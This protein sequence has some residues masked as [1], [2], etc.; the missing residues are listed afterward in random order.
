MFQRLRDKSTAQLFIVFMAVIDLFTCMVIIPMTAFAEFTGYKLQSDPL[1]KIYHF[2]IT[3]K[4][5]LSLFIMVAIAVDRY[6]C[7]CRPL[8]RIITRTRAKII[9]MALTLFACGLGVFSVLFHGMYHA[10]EVLDLEKIDQEAGT[11]LS[12]SPTPLIFKEDILRPLYAL[13]FSFPDC[14]IE[15]PEG[16]DYTDGEILQAANI[17]SMCEIQSL[18]QRRQM[19][20]LDVCDVSLVYLG[21]NMFY[22]YQSAYNAIFPLCLLMVFILYS[23]I[24]RFMCQRRKRKLRQK[25]ILCSY[26]NGDG[27]FENTRLVSTPP[28]PEGQAQQKGVESQMANTGGG[29]PAQL[30]PSSKLRTCEIAIPTSVSQ[31]VCLGEDSDA[32]SHCAATKKPNGDWQSPLTPDGEDKSPL[33][34]EQAL[35]NHLEAASK[36]SHPDL[37]GCSCDAIDKYGYNLMTE[38]STR[39][40]EMEIQCPGKNVFLRTDDKQPTILYHPLDKNNQSESAPHHTNNNYCKDGSPI[41]DNVSGHELSFANKFTEA[42]SSRGDLFEEEDSSRS[43]INCSRRLSH[44]HPKQKYQWH[45][46]RDSMRRYKGKSPGGKPRPQKESSSRR[47]SPLALEADRLSKENRKANVRTALMLFTVTLMFI[48]AY[49]PGWMMSMRIVP[50]N[51]LVFFLYFSYNVANPFIYAFMNHVFKTFMYKMLTCNNPQQSRI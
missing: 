11:N 43:D 36:L 44:C 8:Q 9:I 34:Q 24:Y 7:I 28:G 4:V 45:K 49:T 30:S 17:R 22:A 27:T 20:K 15:I 51:K 33:T 16:G 6:M 14:D 46:N 42:T 3:S 2:L 35:L 5:P 1:C 18:P 29:T 12:V 19:I 47:R 38:I 41:K 50:H 23:L 26:V 21:E 40:P 48:V 25:L 37:L 31:I 13:N 10:I 32:G 39:K